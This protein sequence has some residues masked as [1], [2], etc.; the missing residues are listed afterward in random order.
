MLDNRD[1]MRRPSYRPEWPS[2]GKVLFAN[3]VIFFFQTL[4][5]YYAARKDPGW[6]K[7]YFDI[8][9]LSILG[10]KSGCVWQLFTFQFMHGSGWHLI[11]NSLIIF[12][13]GREI[14]TRFGRGTFLRLYLISGFVGGVFYVLRQLPFPELHDNVCIGASAGAF[15]LLAA[16][17]MLDP[18]RKI[19]LLLMFF[20]PIAIPAWVI[21][22]AEG[23]FTVLSILAP[24]EGD[25]V[26]HAGHLGGL[27]VGMIWVKYYVFGAGWGSIPLLGRISLPKIVIRR[28]SKPQRTTNAPRRAPKS[29][30]IVVRPNEP[31]TSSDAEFISKKI[32]PILD[33]I[34]EKGIHS[35]TDKERAILEKG[36]DRLSG[37]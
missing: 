35:L 6:A 28:K 12:F 20:I 7:G 31:D 25:H 17:C 32:D 26:A 8:F 23:A 27:V 34:R 16:F 19:T 13:C 21:L 18:H 14:E 24:A 1:Y 5:V 33:K 22:A 30:G 36:K 29:R 3:A 4:F 15:G 11:G 10:L 2:W 37:K 9:G